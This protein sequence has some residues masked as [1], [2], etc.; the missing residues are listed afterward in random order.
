MRL[1][2]IMSTEVATVR[3]DESVARANATMRERST[4]WTLKGRGPRRHEVNRR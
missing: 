2:D 4:R 3:T 1:Q